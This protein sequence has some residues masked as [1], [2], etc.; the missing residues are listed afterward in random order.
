MAGE[1]VPIEIKDKIKIVQVNRDV[2]YYYVNYNWPGFVWRNAIIFAILHMLYLYG[3]YLSLARIS[4]INWFFG[5]FQA[6]S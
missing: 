4:W 1:L 2:Q 5:K 3:F 6:D